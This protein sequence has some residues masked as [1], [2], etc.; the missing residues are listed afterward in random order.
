VKQNPERHGLRT[1]GGFVMTAIHRP[2][3]HRS[4]LVWCRRNVKAHLP[5]DGNT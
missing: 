2:E 4:Q 3:Q 1:P 5:T